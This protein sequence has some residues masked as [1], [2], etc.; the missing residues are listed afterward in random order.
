MSDLVGFLFLRV[1]LLLLLSL[2][3]VKCKRGNSLYFLGLSKKK[4]VLNLYL[5]NGLSNS[6]HLDDSTSVFREIRSNFSVLFHFSMKFRSAN[7][8]AS[9][10]TSAFCGISSPTIR[11]G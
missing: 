8:I 2:V 7:R 4:L 10:E 3:T 1:Y 9:D 11:L 5:T 6:Y